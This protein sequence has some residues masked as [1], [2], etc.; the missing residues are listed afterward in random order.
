MVK[1]CIL[2]QSTQVGTGCSLNSVIA[3]KNV[4]IEDGR[5]LTGSESYPVYI[6]KNAKL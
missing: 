5:V 2:M 4:L 3:D 6:G 1:N